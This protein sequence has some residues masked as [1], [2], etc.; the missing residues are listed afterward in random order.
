MVVS[1]LNSKNLFHYH[2]HSRNSFKIPFF[3]SKLPCG[4]FGILDDFIE[5]YQSLDQRFVQN[6]ASTFFF[7]A[8][9]DSMKPTIFPEDILIVD[10][11]IEH[12]EGKVCVVCFEGELLCKRVFTKK[13]H[14]LLLSDNQVYKPKLIQN[15]ENA[16]VWGVVVAKACDV[17]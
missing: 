6:K 4:T 1:F 15:P 13:N 7:R 11:S 2:R 16:F 10:R 14:A 17:K 3:G 12:Y 8:T 5:K 9:G